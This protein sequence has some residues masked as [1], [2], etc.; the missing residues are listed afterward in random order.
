MSL[1]IHVQI[2]SKVNMLTHLVGICATGTTIN[3]LKLRKR[4]LV[5]SLASDFS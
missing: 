4:S 1:S 3:K 2:Y 5:E